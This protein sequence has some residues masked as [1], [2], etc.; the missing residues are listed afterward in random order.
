LST[1]GDIVAM[2]AFGDKS[3]MSAFGDTE[4][5]D[6]TLKGEIPPVGG[7]KACGAGYR[8]TRYHLSR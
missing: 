4:L 7:L 5:L 8:D 6:L 3:E 2:S 1:F